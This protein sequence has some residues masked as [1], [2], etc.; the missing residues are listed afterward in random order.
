MLRVSANPKPMIWTLINHCGKG[1]GRSMVMAA[2]AYFAHI[3]LMVAVCSFA[4]PAQSGGHAWSK[5]FGDASNQSVAGV[6]LDPAGYVVATGSFFGAIDLGGGPLSS[7]GQQDIYLAKF[8]SSGNHVWSRRFGDAVAQ[9]ARS[10]V[11]DGSGNVIVTGYF[12]GSV[13]FGGT[14]LVSAGGSDIFVVK[15]DT[16]G[17]FVWSKRFGDANTQTGN[18]V[19]LDSAGN[20]I[21]TGAVS[22][23][24]DFGGGALASAGQSDIYLVKFDAN[25]NHVWSKR[26]GDANVQAGSGLAVDGSDNVFTT[27]SFNGTLDFGASP[28]TS[29]GGSDIFVAK[30]DSAGG[31][32]WSRRFG[33][34][35]N[36]TGSDVAIDAAGN[37]T[38]TGS[39]AGSIDFGAGALVGA[40]QQDVYL[41]HFNSAGLHLWSRA[42]GGSSDDFGNAVA[43]NASG[44]CIL[45]GSFQ[46]SVDF[47]GGPLTGAGGA[48]LYVARYGPNGQHLSS[49]GYGDATTQSGSSIALSGAGDALVAGDFQGTIDLGGG[50][51]TSAG[52]NDVVLAKFV[53]AVFRDGF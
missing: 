53:D 24:V 9:F 49:S 21:A 39:F 34:A 42:F 19:A 23:S 50:P 20:L 30:F 3:A 43:V 25:G 18:D 37:S 27:G 44:N 38:I 2:R 32:V 47:G 29:A 36:Q 31:F 17:G 12:N 16:N 6:A 41:A 33:D 28:M 26:F 52:G 15:F 10:V 8:D 1:I 40:G 48:D 11:I 46:G 14:S 7:A 13:N 35:T 45:S 4:G 22:G 51:L 5:R